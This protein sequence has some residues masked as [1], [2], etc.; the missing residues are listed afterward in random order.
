[1]IYAVATD[2]AQTTER[3]ISTSE[4][5]PFINKSEVETGITLNDSSF[6]SG[7]EE[8]TP[9]SSVGSVNIHQISEC[10]TNL[11]GLNFTCLA[12][13]GLISATQYKR[14]RDTLWRYIIPT[15]SVTGVLVNILGIW[16]LVSWQCKQSFYIFLLALLIADLI[17]LFTILLQNSILILERYDKRSADYINCHISSSVRAVQWMT[18]S[19]CAHLV[20]SMAFERLL[21]ILFPFWVRKTNLRKQTIV[22]IIFLF[23]FNALLKIP[24]FISNVAKETTDPKTSLTICKSVKSTWAIEYAVFHKHYVTAML[25]MSQF[26]PLAATIAANISIAIFLSRQRAQRMLLLANKATRGEQYQQYMTTITLIILSVCLTLSLVPTASMNTLSRYL[27][28]IYGRQG[29]EKFTAAFV[30]ELGYFLRVFSASTDF[31]VYILMSTSS[32]TV[33][34]HLVKNKCCSARDDNSRDCMDS[35]SKSREGTASTSE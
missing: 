11:T 14:L 18:Y 3:A 32:R 8:V 2:R 4:S 20:T 25:F 23:A 12:R 29:R 15:I 9:D 1:M 22:I 34:V 30:S 19:T 10:E 6:Y 24:A 28:E 7:I 26:V 21:H 5:F 13:L 35:Q 17:Y 27:P 31:I 16:F 33:L